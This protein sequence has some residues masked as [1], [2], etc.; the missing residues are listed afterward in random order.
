M[1]VLYRKYRPQILSQV[2]GQ[3]QI[4]SYFEK[5]LKDNKISHAYLFSGPR[6][7]GKT[8]VARILAKTLNCESP[9]RPCGKCPSCR[10]MLLGNHLDIIE[11]DAASNRGIDD[12]R[13][14]RENVGLLPQMGKYKIYILDEA[15]MLTNDAWNA[16]LKT[17]E[18]PPSHVVFILCTTE[19][20]KLP[21]TIMSRVLRFDFNVP[22]EIQLA[23]FLG[24]IIKEEGFSFSEEAIK[25]LGQKASGSYRDGLSLLE[26][27]ITQENPKKIIDK[28]RL[29]EVLGFP[30]DEKVQIFLTFLSRKEGFG[31]ID[32]IDSSNEIDFSELLKEVLLVL[33]QELLGR[34]KPLFAPDDALRLTKLLM[35]TQKEIKYSDL[36]QLPLE[37]A[38]LEFCQL[39]NQ[40]LLN[41]FN[42][43]DL[44][45]PPKP[46]ELPT[47]LSVGQVDGSLAERVDLMAIW[48]KV[49][50]QV[51]PLNHSIELSLR[52]CRPLS[53][54][55][56]IL[57]L[58]FD[59][60]FHRE[61]IG[62]I[63]NRSL[64]EKVI[65]ELT[66]IPIKIKT[67][68]GERSKQAVFQD[69]AEGI[70]NREEKA[71]S[72]RPASSSSSD[73]LIKA[74]RDLGGT[75]IQ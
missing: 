34:V 30:S 69:R 36:P 3:P 15:H 18:E 10:S 20:Y 70:S 54:Q 61:Q 37:I 48:P 21:E 63:G 7:L 40:N 24:G 9:D 33:R 12:V 60:P 74:A 67:I 32:F 49:L 38:I 11:I 47:K 26:K 19:S 2:F 28:D 14:L 71:E 1:E 4:V 72:P 22:S 31:A 39:N 45:I 58:S 41:S 68:L 8:T 42:R 46:Q 27:V 5:T 23:N 13:S 62:K 29:T 35:N 59:F 16:F 55:N 17:L 56:G 51:K 57:E 65:S 25:L 44:I 53:L 66:G 64:I 50:E 52:A 6:G 73:L 43:P 75:L